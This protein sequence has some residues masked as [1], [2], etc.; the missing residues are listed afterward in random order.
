MA[1]EKEER[2]RGEV[3]I[4]FKARIS[5]KGNS[6]IRQI[7]YM[8]SSSAIQYFAICKSFYERINEKQE[9]GLISETVVQR[10]LLGLRCLLPF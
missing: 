7:M 5:E 4:I 8:P 2:I 9:N 3:I 10:K 6:H 1:E